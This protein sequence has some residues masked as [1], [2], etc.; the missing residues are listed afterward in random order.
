MPANLK[1][2]RA[3]HGKNVFPAGSL[4]GGDMLAGYGGDANWNNLMICPRKVVQ[5]ILRLFSMLKYQERS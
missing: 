2:A 3:I 4:Y 1:I 5:K